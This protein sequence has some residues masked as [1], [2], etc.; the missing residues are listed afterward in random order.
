MAVSSH[1]QGRQPSNEM[2]IGLKSSCDKMELFKKTLPTNVNAYRLGCKIGLFACL[3]VC[4][5]V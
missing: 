5:F 4:L 2:G 1:D 3:F